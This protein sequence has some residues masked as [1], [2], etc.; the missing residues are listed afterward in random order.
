MSIVNSGDRDL[1]W[2]TASRSAANGEC[3]EVASAL[4]RISIRD[5]KDPYGPILSCSTDTFRS[6]LNT[7]KKTAPL[8]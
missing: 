1:S 5:S 6:F 2:R 7:A 8:R 4:G 3:V